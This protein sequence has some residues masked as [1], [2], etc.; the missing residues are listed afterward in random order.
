MN[1]TKKESSCI[2]YALNSKKNF[3]DQKILDFQ[4]KIAAIP[5]GV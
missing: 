2:G 4:K 3:K 1:S 5:T